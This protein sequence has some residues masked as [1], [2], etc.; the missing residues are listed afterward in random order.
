MQGDKKKKKL[1]RKRHKNITAGQTHY[2]RLQMHQGP[3]SL[4][5]CYLMYLK[6]VYQAAINPL[7]VI[8]INVT[9]LI[10][11]NK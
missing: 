11:L 8:S 6:A 10:S 2:E 7:K 3:R 5:S 1:I 4:S 9:F